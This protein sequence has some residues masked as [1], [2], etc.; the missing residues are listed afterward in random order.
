MSGEEKIG[1]VTVQKVGLFYRIACRCL[2]TGTVRYRLVARCG[3]HSVDLGLCVPH[4][5]QF[6]VDTSIPMKR[7]GDGELS[8]HLIPKH[9]RLEG[10]FVPVSPYK[11]FAH[12][13]QL[14]NAR[15]V[16]SDGEIGVV[17]PED[18]S[19]SD[20]PTGQWSD[21]ITSE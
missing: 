20:K 12:I 13:Q 6:G 15:F 14:Q 8:F 17:L 9:D 7:L 11:P 10:L 4:G 21:P 19:S 5:H 16:R 3:E 1:R 2:L 18:Q